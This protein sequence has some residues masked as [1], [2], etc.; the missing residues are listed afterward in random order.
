MTWTISTEQGGLFKAQHTI[1]ATGCLSAFNRVKFINQESFEGEEYFTGEWPHED[2]DFTG[3]RV[4]VIG[5]GSSGIQVSPMVAQQASS[6]KIFQRTPQFVVPQRNQPQDPAEEAEL[7]KRYSEHKRAQRLDP[8]FITPLGT[9]SQ[10]IINYT[11]AEQ[12]KVLNNHAELGGFAATTT[13][14]DQFTN[15]EAASVV[16]QYYKD[17]IKGIVQDPVTAAKLTPD[18]TFACKR[19]IMSDTYY[20]MFN[21]DSVSLVTSKI[22]AFTKDGIRTADGVEHKFDVI[23]HATGF[24]S[25]TGSALRIDIRGARGRTLKQAW[26][27]GARAYL[28][29]AV[30][31]FPNL[32]LITGPQSPSV[33]SNMI[34]TIQQ[35][36]DWVVKTILYMKRRSINSIDAQEE[37]TDAWVALNDA[38]AA[39]TIWNMPGAQCNSWYRGQNIDGKPHSFLPFAGGT[40]VFGQKLEAVAEAGYEGF[41]LS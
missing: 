26:N 35:H 12:E 19:L 3:K 4:A 17:R 16:G 34:P 31:S 25:M 7:K 13:F 11:K 22:E 18:Y 9:T 38:I 36:S 6:L 28:G 24:D 2:V 37:A 14:S 41:T 5:T 8:G 30:P 33:L 15:L 10:P 32:F 29:T 39:S 1:L 23:V 21:R 40:I 27:V 20:Q